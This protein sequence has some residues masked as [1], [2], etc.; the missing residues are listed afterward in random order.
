MFCA[1]SSNVRLHD[2]KGRRE[3]LNFKVGET[4][5]RKYVPRVSV[6]TAAV[7]HSSPEWF[8]SR[9]DA[10][11]DSPR[12]C[13]N[14]LDE[15]ELPARSEYPKDFANGALLVHDAAEDEC[16]DDEVYAGAFNRQIFSRPE[17]R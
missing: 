16:A 9:L 15:E 1:K 12:R 3:L 11:Q 17:L 10:A 2:G 13:G 6:R 7:S 5:T 4:G 14:V 8:H